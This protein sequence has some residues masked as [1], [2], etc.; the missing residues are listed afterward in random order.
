MAFKKIRTVNFKDS[1][2][3]RMQDNV[4]QGIDSLGQVPL[5]DGVL[6]ENVVLT[7]GITNH[8]PHKLQRPLIGWMITR[9]R[10]NSIVWDSQ[11]AA[12]QP[13]QILDLHCSANVTVD[14]WVF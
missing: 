4:V 14:I 8:I 10:A 2:I 11:D 9:M 6:I 1:D 5:I 3:N 7:T 12:A 13:A